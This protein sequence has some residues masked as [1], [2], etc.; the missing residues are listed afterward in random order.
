MALRQSRMGRKRKNPEGPKPLHHIESWRRL[1]N[2]TQEQ[3]A[4]LVGMSSA[5]ISQLETGETKPT[6]D[7]LDKLARALATRRGNLLDIDPFANGAAVHLEA[8][9]METATL[10]RALRVVKALD[11][12]AS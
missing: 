11:A 1:R 3:L 6:F 9:E 2:L 5:A 10:A 12:D 7:T 4:E 8:Q